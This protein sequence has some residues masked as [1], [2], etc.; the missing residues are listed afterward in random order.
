[1]MNLYCVYV[2]KKFGAYAKTFLGVTILI[3]GVSC[4]SESKMSTKERIKEEVIVKLQRWESR[5]AASCRSTAMEIALV[6]ADSLILEYA[7][8]QKLQLERPSKPIRPEEPELRRPN[9]T[10]KLEPF[11]QDSM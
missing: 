6:N 7:R 3:L 2:S 9:D 8:E 4:N 1:M 10:L 5:R 11:L